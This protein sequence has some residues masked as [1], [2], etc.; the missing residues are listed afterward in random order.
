M[1]T[2]KVTTADGDYWYSGINATL[3]EARAYF[4]G[5]RFEKLVPANNW[6]KVREVLRE[7]VVTVEEV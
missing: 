4:L 2:V 6:C 3:D 5:Q 7:P 1:I